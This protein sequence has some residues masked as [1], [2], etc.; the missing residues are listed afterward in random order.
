VLKF[1]TGSRALKNC[2]THAHQ[3]FQVQ[4]EPLRVSADFGSASGSGARVVPAVLYAT[5]SLRR[6]TLALG[7]LICNKRSILRRFGTRGPPC[8]D[9][10]H[11]FEI[12]HIVIE[13]VVCILLYIVAFDFADHNLLEFFSSLVT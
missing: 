2:S 12:Q 3:C 13:H 9:V 5:I 10:F 1:Q 11:L 4:C 8:L 7:R 6:F